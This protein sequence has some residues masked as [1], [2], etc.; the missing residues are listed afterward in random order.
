MTDEQYG[1]L[2]GRLSALEL[3]M[4]I[5]ELK[6]LRGSTSVEIDQEAKRRA[7]FWKQ[8]GEALEGEEPE[9][10]GSART[11]SLERLG[12]LLVQFAGPITEEFERLGLID[13]R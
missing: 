8:I 6:N 11:R 2:I 13:N 3:L 7:D 1:Q 4:I 12:N 10:I 5:N 9:T